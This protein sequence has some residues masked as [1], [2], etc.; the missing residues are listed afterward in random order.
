[1]RWRV[2]IGLDQHPLD[3]LE[4]F[5]QNGLEQLFLAGEIPVQVPLAHL[6]CFDDV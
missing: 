5:S 2:G 1:M 6:G 4:T 3:V